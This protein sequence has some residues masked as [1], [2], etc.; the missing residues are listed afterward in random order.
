[1]LLSGSLIQAAHAQ[2]TLAAGDIAIIGYNASGTPDS[3]A[4]LVLKDLSAGTQFFVSDNEVASVGGTS[5][6]DASEAE[7]TFTVQTGQTVAAG[8]VVVL[9]WGNQ[10]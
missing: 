8:T 6:A 10:T 1:I 9:P 7:A 5:F 2:T 4:L 3:I